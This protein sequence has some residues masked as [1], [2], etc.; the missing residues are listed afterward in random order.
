ML[1]WNG[2]KGLVGPALDVVR[3]KPA[4]RAWILAFVAAATAL[5]LKGQS[6]QGLWLFTSDLV[7]VLLF[8]QL[9]FALFDRKANRTGS[10]VAFAVSL[11]LRAGG[12]EPLLGLPQLIPYPDTVPFR[13]LAA[14]AGFILLPIVSRATSRWDRPQPLRNPVD[15]DNAAGAAG[16]AQTV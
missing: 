11:V 8:P 14:A 16:V 6:A 3:M 2:L 4:I 5:A 10:M 1:S 7:F 9:V 15:D 13:T 12:G